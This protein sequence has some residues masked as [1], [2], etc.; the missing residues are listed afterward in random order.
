LITERKGKKGERLTKETEKLFKGKKTYRFSLGNRKGRGEASVTSTFKTKK[1]QEF[2]RGGM[3]M[4]VEGKWLLLR[5]RGFSQLLKNKGCAMG[6]NE[7]LES[8]QS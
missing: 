1:T 6:G 3:D 2:F 4:T 5:V 8:H 7:K